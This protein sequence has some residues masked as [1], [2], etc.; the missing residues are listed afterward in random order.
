MLML[1]VPIIKVNG[2]LDRQPYMIARQ[3]KSVASFV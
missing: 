3:L 1:I 2:T